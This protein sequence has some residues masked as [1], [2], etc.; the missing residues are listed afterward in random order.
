[1]TTLKVKEVTP[2]AVRFS[3]MNE[4]GGIVTEEEQRSAEQYTAIE[5]DI[6]NGKAIYP[7]ISRDLKLKYPNRVYATDSVSKP[8]KLIIWRQS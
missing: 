6:K 8:G 5:T 3:W 7:L 4:L 2:P 1:M